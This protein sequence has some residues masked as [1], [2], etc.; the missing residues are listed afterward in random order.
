MQRIMQ[1]VL[2]GRRHVHIFT[3]RT[4]EMTFTDRRFYKTVVAAV[5]LLAA[6]ILASGATQAEVLGVT[7]VENGATLSSWIQSSTPVVDASVADFVTQVETSGTDVSYFNVVAVFGGGLMTPD[8]GAGGA[9]FIYQTGQMYSGSEASPVFGVG[10]FGGF[11]VSDQNNA[12]VTFTAVNVA[13]ELSTWAMMLTGFAGLGF[14]GY[15]ASS[16]KSATLVV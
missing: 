4:S 13:P 8:V 10:S 6:S 5:A 7:V 2:N 3:S 16:R 9:H 14:V 1:R 12:T 15:R 11:D